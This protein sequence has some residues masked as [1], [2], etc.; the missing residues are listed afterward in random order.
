MPGLKRVKARLPESTGE[1]IVSLV[2]A[3]QEAQT[4]LL[5]LVDPVVVDHGER[6]R[7]V[8]DELESALEFLLDDGVEEPADAQLA[9]VQ[10]FHA[11]IGQRSSSLHQ[12]LS[13]Y[14]TLAESLKARLIEVDEDFDVALIAE[15]KELARELAAAPA[16]PPAADSEIKEA[17]RIRNGL[18][19]LLQEKIALVRKAAARVFQRNPEVLREV[20]S[21]Y[22]RRRRTAARRARAA[23]DAAKPQ[24]P[25]AA[26]SNGAGE[27]PLLG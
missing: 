13:D 2:Y 24:D 22:E 9:A 7:F 1:E 4:K 19:R 16:A 3:V 10:E 23:R 15:A 17:T 6:A 25:K 8:L 11:D 27:S 12:A 20:T 21:S 14:A 26:P 18:L 5:L